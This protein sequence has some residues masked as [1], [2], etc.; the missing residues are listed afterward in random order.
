MRKG[1]QRFEL[2][3]L[4]RIKNF[5]VVNPLSIKESTRVLFIY[6]RKPK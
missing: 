5:L 2:H 6:C 3:R 4:L 1:N